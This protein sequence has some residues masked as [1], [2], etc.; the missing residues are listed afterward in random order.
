ML[1]FSKDEF[2]WGEGA[3]IDFID[4]N[5][6]I[7]MAYENFATH[8]SVGSKNLDI[9]SHLY[10]E[11][12]LKLPSW[13]PDWTATI[14]NSPELY[15]NRL[16]SLHMYNASAGLEYDGIVITGI[17]QYYTK[18]VFF[19][20]I[21][22]VLPPLLNSQNYTAIRAAVGLHP[23]DIDNSA[24]YRP[25]EQTMETALYHTLAGGIEFNINAEH[26]LC[27][28]RM[29]PSSETDLSKYGR[30]LMFFGTNP[31]DDLAFWNHDVKCVW[32]AI[33]SNVH[34]RVFIKTRNECIGFAPLDS[35]K[36]DF[37]AV[38]AGGS[39]PYILVPKSDSESDTAGEGS[40]TVWRNEF[41]IRGD[42]YIH[43]IMDGEVGEILEKS[44]TQPQT[45]FLV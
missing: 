37:I 43:G 16:N 23:S 15:I 26:H 41:T 36:G 10:G 5:K 33:M 4:Y 35:K 21:D 17:G 22:E 40:G 29:P 30:W 6:S 27:P 3:Q 39:V 24:R 7:E 13:V 8:V 32:S 11:R 18:G 34:D 14:S 19:D 28:S 25:T 38:L 2:F 45:I 9:L 44:K 12:K 31:L 1:G 20:V 42:C